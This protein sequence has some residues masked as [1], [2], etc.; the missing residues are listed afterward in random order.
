[1]ETEKQNLVFIHVPVAEYFYFFFQSLH[2]KVFQ[3]YYTLYFE[4]RVSLLSVKVY[5]KIKKNSQLK[6]VIPTCI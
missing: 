1:M 2:V 5:K 6:S 4:S 3:A